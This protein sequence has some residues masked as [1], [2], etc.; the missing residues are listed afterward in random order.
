MAP[1]TS[2]QYV[3][4]MFAQGRMAE[5]S[6]A[7]VR[8][9]TFRFLVVALGLVAVVAVGFLINDAVAPSIGDHQDILGRLANLQALRHSGNVYVP[10][11]SEAFTYPP[12]AILL[13]WPILWVS[14]NVLTVSWTLLSLAALVVTL[15]VLINRFL[16]WDRWLS[17]GLACWMTA[18]TALVF[19]PILEGLTWGQTGTLLLALVVLDFLIVRGSPKGVLVGLA[20]AFKIYPGLF[21][22]A[23]LLRREWRA[24]FTALATA[25]ATTALAWLLWPRSASTFFTKELFGGHE[26]G[27]FASHAAVTASSSFSAMFMRPPFHVGL[28][29][30][31]GTFGACAIV[32]IVGLWSSHR[33]W[34]H[35]REL[36]AMVVLLIA[37]AIG[38]P[39]AWDHYFSFAPLLLFVPLEIGVR[40]PLSRVALAS[41]VVMLVPWFR[42]RRPTASSWW[43]S[44]YA[45]IGRNALLFVSLVMLVT[46]LLVSSDPARSHGRR[47]GARTRPHTRGAPVVHATERDDQRASP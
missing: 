35:G 36:S 7:F 11:G 29:N 37:S 2:F 23:W 47:A 44:C 20:T 39:L 25:G 17:V 38:A 8:S 9:G 28:L 10:F 4:V 30:D 19:P 42:F 21:I 27:H 34:S 15:A 33:L 6:P 16:L 13:F 22:V 31:Y 14:V 40:N 43:S 12:G 24:A 1:P 41:A 5:R 32:M 26:L 46:P 18:L 3:R 45:F